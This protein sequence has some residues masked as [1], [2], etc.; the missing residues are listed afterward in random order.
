MFNILV[1][2]LIVED[3]KVLLVKEKKNEVKDLLNLPA[4]HLERNETL[5]EAAKR[6]VMEETG[7]K[8]NIDMLID[9]QY[10]SKTEK[11]YVSFVFQGSVVKGYKSTN[12]L[13]YAFYDIDFIKKNKQ[14][15]R[16]DKLILS[17]I[18]KTNKGSKTAIAII[19]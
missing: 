5:I 6:E 9:T 15:L 19:K 7:L 14:I 4:G 18:E 8:I 13:D 12:E 17:A 16:N 2:T 3:N 10:F 11:D 1:A